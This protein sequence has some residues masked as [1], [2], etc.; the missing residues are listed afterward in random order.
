MLVS[1]DYLLGQREVVACS[2]RVGIVEYDRQSVAWALAKLDVAL[3]D[4]LENEFLEVTFHLVVDLVGQSEAAV[5]HGQEEPFYLES[6][7]E[8]ALNDLDGVEQ[9]ANSL[10]CEVLTLHGNDDRI[11]CCQCIHGDES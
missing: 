7:V 1:T 10:E 6:W 11:G 9:L 3:D 2:C 4:G 8:L 5:I